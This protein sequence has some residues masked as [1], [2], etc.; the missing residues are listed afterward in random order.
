MHQ[1]LGANSTEGYFMHV[2]GTHVAYEPHSCWVRRLSAG[3]A[4]QCLDGK[5]VAFIGD[6][7][8]RYGGF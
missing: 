6:S 5:F 8:T 3:A 1:L 7:V 2:D 4:R